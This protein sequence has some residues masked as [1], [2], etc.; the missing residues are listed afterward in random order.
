MRISDWSSDVCSSDLLLEIVAVVIDL[1]PDDLGEFH[2]EV[3]AVAGAEIVAWLRRV[4]PRPHPVEQAGIGRIVDGHAALPV[5]T[6]DIFGIL[7]LV[8]A[9]DRA[10]Q[11]SRADR[12]GSAAVIEVA[13][14]AGRLE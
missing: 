2:H 6:R 5:A 7:G 3:N 9:L 11:D 8:I 12:P 10:E 4:L 1:E 14:L 13:V